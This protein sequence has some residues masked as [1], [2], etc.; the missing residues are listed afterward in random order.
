MIFLRI[1]ALLLMGSNNDI[2]S[3]VGF[4]DNL[5]AQNQWNN[6]LTASFASRNNACKLEFDMQCYVISK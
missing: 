5:F 1:V 6:L 2:F 3:F 4:R